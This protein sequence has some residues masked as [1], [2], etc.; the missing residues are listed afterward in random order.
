MGVRNLCQKM[1]GNCS[2]E[3]KK[4]SRLV[5]GPHDETLSVI[6]VCV[7]NSDRRPQESTAETQPQL[8]PGLAEIVSDDLPVVSLGSRRVM[9][10][11]KEHSRG[12]DLFSGRLQK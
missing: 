8:Q 12:S 2:R 7:N 4:R 1:S 11:S 10:R 9:S 5:I 3:F 6:A